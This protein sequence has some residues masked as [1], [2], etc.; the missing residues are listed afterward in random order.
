MQTGVPRLQ[1]LAGAPQL[2][3]SL[4]RS[5]QAPFTQAG[6]VPPQT[7]PQP[8]QLNA[9]LSTST[10]PAPQSSVPAAQVQTPPEQLPAPQE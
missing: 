1:S 5:T 4:S 8:L 9:F 7:V 10:Q 6:L 2:L 3:R